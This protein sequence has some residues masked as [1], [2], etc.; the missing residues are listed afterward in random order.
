MQTKSNKKNIKQEEK[1]IEFFTLHFKNM[2]QPKRLSLQNMFD[3]LIE[4]NMYP[5]KY[6]FKDGF[7]IVIDI[8]R[9]FKPFISANQGPFLL[10]D[11]RLGVVKRG[12]MHSIINLQEYTFETNDIIFVGPGSIAEPIEM[13]DDFMLMGIGIPSDMFNLAH[14]GNLPELFKGQ[15]KH[16][17]QR[18]TTGQMQLLNHMFFLLWE[19]AQ[20]QD[21]ASN[22][23]ASQ[24]VLYN[25]LSTI[26]HYY[27][28]LLTQ[29]QP[30]TSGHSSANDIFDRFLQLVNNHCQQE[31]QLSF[32]AEKI[33]ITERY[34]STVI[35]QTSGITAK[36]WIDKAVIT[37]AKVKL[38]HSNLQIAEI[39]ETLHFPNPSF[40][41]KYFK[42]LVGCTPQEYRLR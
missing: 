12:K 5:D 25:M 4:Q 41:C 9:L 35:R 3:T 31:R 30:K 37:A 28:T 42:R 16:G 10:E 36:E 17:K 20:A 26:T 32:Y 38:R 13:S 39:T 19:I 6:Y 29:E 7:A 8:N 22:K 2:K 27:N 15:S 34:L 23:E 40:F 24:Q 1:A 21:E 11:Y 33:C 14:P 18:I